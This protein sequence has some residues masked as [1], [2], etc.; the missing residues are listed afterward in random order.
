MSGATA[1]SLYKYRDENGALVFSDVPPVTGQDFERQMLR[2]SSQASP[3]VTFR[4]ETAGN[5]VTLWVN[6][7]CLCVVEVIAQAVE[8]GAVT[9]PAR[10]A[11]RLVVPSQSVMQLLT[12]DGDLLSGS[13]P[14][15]FK[16]AWVLGDP[17]ASHAPG[18][19]YRPPF[20]AARQFRV[21]QA[22]PDAITHSTPDSRYAID[23]AMPEKT[24]VYAA[25]GGLVIEVAHSNFRGGADWGKF[26]A[27]ANL[28]RVLHDDG[29]L[30]LYAHLSWDSIRV[31]VGQR[32]ERGELIAASGNTGFS[33]GPHLHFVVVRNVGLRSE[34]VPVVFSAGNG[35][36]VMPQTGGYLGNP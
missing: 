23:I 26:G 28:I 18:Q 24:A 14:V 2:A 36:V 5:D 21:S 10:K 35:E 25:R 1:D 8:N 17:E 7:P 19:P 3:V 4:Q 9:G 22:F 30:A 11:T 27:D 32:V 12:I 6:N 34:S 16:T 29:S 20:A 31:R 13:A 33:T 15:E